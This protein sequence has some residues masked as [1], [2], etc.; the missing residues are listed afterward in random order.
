MELDFIIALQSVYE[1]LTA[2]VQL[3][4]GNRSRP[5]AVQRG[6]RQGDPLSPILFIN[7]LRDLL[8]NISVKWERESRRSIV[9]AWGDAVGRLTHI[10]F[11]DDTTLVAKSKK[12]LKVMLKDIELA[13]ASA[14]LSLNLAK[15]KI[16]T[17]KQ[18]NTWWWMIPDIRLFGQRWVSRCWGHSSP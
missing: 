2:Y 9:G 14:G 15:C 11:A 1:D 12:D 17:N 10:L 13:F 3:E 18:T 8:K 7:V 16:Q 5:F 4:P 6:V